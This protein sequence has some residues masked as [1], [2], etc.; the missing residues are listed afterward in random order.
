MLPLPSTKYPNVQRTVT[1]V[2]DVFA[3][4]VIFNCDTTT[5]AVTINLGEIPYN[6]TTGVGYWST[7]YKLY[8]NDISNNAGT[9][10]ITLVAGLGQTINNAATAVLNT[11]GAN[12]Y[13]VI[14][15]N[16]EYSVFYAPAQTTPT[17][18]ISVTW[19]Q[20]NALIT[21]NTLVPNANYNVTDA[22]FGS[23]PIIP[24][25]IYIQALTTNTVSLSGQGYFLNA[26][27]QAVGDYS[28]VVGFTSQLGVWTLALVTPIGSVVI[29]NNFQ[30]VNTTGVNGVANP[31]T[32]V[33]N[34]TVLP[35]VITNGYVVEISFISYSPTNNRIVS[36]RDRFNNF[37]E[38]TVLTFRNSLNFFK[39]GSVDVRQ[40]TV[41]KDSVLYN[42]NA[43]TGGAN[44]FF[45]NDFLDSEVILGDTVAQ[46]G[47]IVNWSNNVIELSPI[48]FK[49]LGGTLTNN[50]FNKFNFQGEN[51]GTIT[52]NVISSATLDVNNSGTI[53]NNVFKNIRTFTIT[54]NSGNIFQNEV[55]SGSFEITLENKGD[56]TNNIFNN[57]GFNIDT[58]DVNSAITNNTSNTSV[59][60]VITNQADIAFNTLE[61]QSRLLIGTNLVG[62]GIKY[63]NITN[64]SSVQLGNVSQIIGTGAKGGGVNVSNASILKIDTFSP[65]VGT[66]YGNVITNKSDVK[67][68]TF[69]NISSFFNNT[70]DSTV[71]YTIDLN[72]QDL[73]SN[74][75][76]S[77]AFGGLT[78]TVPFPV[79]FFEKTA[80]SG[81]STVEFE[82]DCSDPT[83]YDLANTRLILSDN[84]KAMG[85]VYKLVNAGGLTISKIGGLSAN[86][87]TEFYTDSGVTT[88][89]GVSV[90]GALV[91][92]I[93]SS[94][95]AVAFNI[96]THA[97]GYDSM[98]F[99][100]ETVTVVRNTNILV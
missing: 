80:M 34:W 51:T 21:A 14:T 79:S 11:N 59:I 15:G 25:S 60:S 32:D 65:T 52:G 90:A 3:D 46:G 83:V 36:R 53:E 84:I 63:F 37:V 23:T 62:G 55:I 40:N 66:F 77:V 27:Y 19:A 22:E 70:I 91:E 49:T 71:F 67:I 1:G 73:N 31:Q 39:W 92:E 18:F 6:A 28:G 57:S 4:D 29:W 81:N 13:V 12:A 41:S 24:T 100:D 38:R 74:F 56:I 9:N 47:N 45:G 99:I 96:T 26:D 87:V 78:P 7:Q 5:G 33:A 88:F 76:K 16:T 85:G 86:W 68:L 44:S 2:V 30:Y 20:L 97:L 42:C 72:D 54:V 69:S 89:Q 95:G 8:I 75:F 82:L 43:I 50:K 93:V 64:L 35:R 17:N 58:N 10:S 61:N 94:S 98:F 48:N